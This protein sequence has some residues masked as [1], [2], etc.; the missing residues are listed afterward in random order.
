MTITYVW[1]PTSMMCYPTY[2]GE[3]DVVFVVNSTVTATDESDPPI[4]ATS[5]N[6]VAI[7]FNPNDPYIPY[8]DL[9]PEIVNKWVQDALGTEQIAEI[10]SALYTQIADII[11]PPVIAP[12]LPWAPEPIEDV[13]DAEAAAK[14]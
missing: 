11:N 7:I 6:S 1:T 2:Q 8:A 14:P 4:S 13:A 12:P 9:T 10:Q 3:T 5:G